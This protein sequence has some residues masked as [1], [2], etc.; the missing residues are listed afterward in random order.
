MEV[1]PGEEVEE[2]RVLVWVEHFGVEGDYDPIVVSH[3][4][5]DFCRERLVMG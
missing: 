4:A 3:T 5:F 1:E 2:G